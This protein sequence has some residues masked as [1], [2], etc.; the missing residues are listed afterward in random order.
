MCICQTPA[1]SFLWQLLYIY[2]PQK[3]NPL[4]KNPGAMCQDNR[5][6]PRLRFQQ[7]P[8]PYNSMYHIAGILW[9]K[10]VG[11]WIPKSLKI[12]FFN[13]SRCLNLCEASNKGELMT[14]F[15][16]CIDVY[17]WYDQRLHSVNRETCHVSLESQVLIGNH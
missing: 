10:A 6:W 11:V 17:R 7:V 15:T 1:A 3:T 14:C 16:H 9:S 5:H 2:T 4:Q 8:L 13:Y 12:F